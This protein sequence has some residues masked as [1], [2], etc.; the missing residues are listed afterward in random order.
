MRILQITG[1][2]ERGGTQT[3]IMNVYRVLRKRG[4][5]FDFLLFSDSKEGFY[6]EAQSLGSK[7][8]V[9]PSRKGNICRYLSGL[10][11]FFKEHSSEYNYVHFSGCTLTTIAPLYYAKKYHIPHR[12]VHA[13]SASWEGIHNYILHSIN[14][15]L[16]SFVATD[17]LACSIKAKDFFYPTKLWDKCIILKNGINLCQFSFNNDIRNKVREKLGISDDVLVI[18]HVGRFATVKNHAFIIEVFNQIQ[19]INDNVLLLLLGNGEL[20]D[21]VK[22]KVK[23]LDLERKVLFLG[24]RDD[25][26]RI[27]QAFDLVL[28]PSLYEGLPFSLIEAQASGLKIFSSDRVSHEVDVTGNV[29]FLSLNKSAHS[30]AEFICN[31]STNVRRNTDTLIQKKGY[32]IEDTAQKLFTIYN[33]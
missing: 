3:F 30:W 19:Q 8:F 21:S 4:V 27:L 14:R 10:K 6:S 1:S 33:S 7:I 31:H 29:F 18:G 16:I 26:Y 25:V 5:I 9:L 23:E 12:I 2:L 22:N 20:L 15:K 11:T 32:S 28:F 17:F 13:H 24:E